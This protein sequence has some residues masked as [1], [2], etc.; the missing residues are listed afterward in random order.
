LLTA[1]FQRDRIF[2]WE[3]KRI[4]DRI[5]NERGPQE[6]DMEEQIRGIPRLISNC[7]WLYHE[8]LLSFEGPRFSSP[9]PD[10]FQEPDGRVEN[11]SALWKLPAIFLVASPAQEIPV[12]FRSIS[13]R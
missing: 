10:P 5:E 1:T 8:I 11:N 9:N 3:Q 13:K 7:P 12:E 4:R 2:S 6:P